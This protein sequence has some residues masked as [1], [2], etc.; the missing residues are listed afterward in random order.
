MD[1]PASQPLLFYDQD[2]SRRMDFVIGQYDVTPLDDACWQNFGTLLTGKVVVLRMTLKRPSL[3]VNRPRWAEN[4]CAF[5]LEDGGVMDRR[6]AGRK[7]FVSL[8]RAIFFFFIKSSPYALFCCPTPSAAFR[9]DDEMWTALGV[10][11]KTAHAPPHP[12]LTP[13]S[14]LSILPIFTKVLFCRRSYRYQWSYF[15]RRKFMTY[16]LG[17]LVERE[18]RFVVHQ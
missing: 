18:K 15:R 14:P 11:V 9:G 4:L 7:I 17:A 1:E 3:S 16:R 13:L 6:T 12:T 2:T 5:H 10:K 8:I